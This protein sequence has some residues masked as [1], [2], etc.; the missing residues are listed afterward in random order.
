MALSLTTNRSKV[1][2]PLAPD[3]VRFVSDPH[4]KASYAAALAGGHP[5]GRRVAFV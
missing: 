2:L 4:A 1:L 3:R 5:R